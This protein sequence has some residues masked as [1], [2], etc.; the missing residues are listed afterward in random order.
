[1][2]KQNDGIDGVLQ[3]E[4]ALALLLHLLGQTGIGRRGRPRLGNIVFFFGAVG[5]ELGG[6]YDFYDLWWTD[7]RTYR[8]KG[9]H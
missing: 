4:D 9:H 3:G 6:F 2:S 1:M 5:L 7:K 8:G